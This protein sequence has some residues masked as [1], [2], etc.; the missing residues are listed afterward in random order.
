M[1]PCP[2]SCGNHRV[3]AHLGNDPHLHPMSPQ[4]AAPLM[5]EATQARDP[6]G[7]VLME[8]Q[9]IGREGCYAAV[10]EDLALPP[11]HAARRPLPSGDATLQR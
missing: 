1:P 3:A 6:S 2:R 5:A 9:R 10:R 7:E 4:Q 8:R 11:G